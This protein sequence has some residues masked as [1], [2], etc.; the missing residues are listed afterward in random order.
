MSSEKMLCTWCGRSTQWD[1]GDASQIYCCEKCKHEHQNSKR[2][3]SSSVEANH[4]KRKPS[5]EC[6][7][8]DISESSST[9]EN[10]SKGCFWF[11]AVPY[12][13]F[14]WWLEYGGCPESLQQPLAII[15]AAPVMLLVIYLFYKK[16]IE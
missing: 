7:N 5:S 9:E 16:H 2:N 6:T 4:K 14:G 11:F 8:S 1:G 13:G 3:K 10:A 15:A 12:I